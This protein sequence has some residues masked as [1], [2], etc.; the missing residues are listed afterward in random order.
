MLALCHVPSISEY[1]LSRHSQRKYGVEVLYGVTVCAFVAPKIIGG[2][3]APSP[4]GELGMAQKFI[5][6]DN[7][8]AFNFV[9]Q[10]KISRSPEE[11]ARIGRSVQRKYPNMNQH[12]KKN[13][14]LR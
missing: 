14:K 13:P 8:Q 9:E 4:V 5:G 10:I 1:E 7:L 6:V 12:K 11:A 2:V 3:N